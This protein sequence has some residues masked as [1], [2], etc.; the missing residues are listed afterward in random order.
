MVIWLDIFVRFMFFFVFF[1]GVK[2]KINCDYCKNKDGIIN[3]R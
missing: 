1:V 2:V 3:K